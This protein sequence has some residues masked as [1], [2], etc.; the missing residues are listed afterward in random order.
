MTVVV[1]TVTVE[2]EPAEM[3]VLS[4]TIFGMFRPCSLLNLNRYV[5]VVPSL[6]H[7]DASTSLM[8]GKVREMAADV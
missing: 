5:R 6:P 4:I 2:V 1:V 3:C 7:F 8:V